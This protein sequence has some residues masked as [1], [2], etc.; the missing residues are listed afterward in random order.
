MARLLRIALLSLLLAGLS[1]QG[2]WADVFACSGEQQV[3]HLSQ[4][5]AAGVVHVTSHAHQQYSAMQD[6]GTLASAGCTAMAL[7][8]FLSDSLCL[9]ASAGVVVAPGASAAVFLT[10]GP[11]RPPRA[12]SA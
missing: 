8:P 6:C 12:I 2:A 11:D 7:L 1:V 3:Q 5:E 10:G 4:P 9:G